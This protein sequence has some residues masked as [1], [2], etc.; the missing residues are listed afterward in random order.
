M[1]KIN[2]E[3][4]LNLTFIGT[5]DRDGKIDG[6]NWE[7]FLKSKSVYIGVHNGRFHAD[8]VFCVALLYLMKYSYFRYVK[9][10]NTQYPSIVDFINHSVIRASTVAD[11]IELGIKDRPYII[12]DVRGGHYDHHQVNQY[13]TDHVYNYDQL[14]RDLHSDH[15][16][17]LDDNY[18][19]LCSFASLWI[20]LGKIFKVDLSALSEEEKACY[21]E[22][23]IDLNVWSDIMEELCIPISLVDTNG[24]EK[25]NCTYNK[26]ISDLNLTEENIYNELPGR[27][28]NFTKAVEI[29]YAIL[30]S[31]IISVQNKYS[32]IAEAY[33]KCSFKENE[34][35]IAYLQ[36]PEVNDPD[37]E[38]KLGIPTL[39]ELIIPGKQRET[40]SRPYFLFNPNP[41][42]RDGCC[43][44]VM[45][46]WGKFDVESIKKH[47][48]KCV[49]IH[50]DGFLVTFSNKEDAEEFIKKLNVYGY[51][52]DKIVLGI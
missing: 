38:V 11:L 46:K 4:M 36:I 22:H 42:A 8:D 18:R 7:E 32:A 40:A 3:I 37:D 13:Y 26:I 10:N 34:H 17:V 16:K 35:L 23:K 12:C 43:R 27:D 47:W 2:K 48:S 45:S 28:P 39:N 24:P 9:H 20:E 30:T 29:A 33:E 25:F 49:F 52:G 51:S 50:P 15:P 21:D 41:A 44:I 19:R 14:I 1:I 6:V 31:A 5:A